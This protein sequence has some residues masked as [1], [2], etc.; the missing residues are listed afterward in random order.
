MPKELRRIRITITL[1][2]R[3]HKWVSSHKSPGEYVEHCIGL[4]RLISNEQ[5]GLLVEQMQKTNQGVDVLVHEAV[6]RYLSR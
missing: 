1:L 6:K 3:Y 5:F 2:S 4:A